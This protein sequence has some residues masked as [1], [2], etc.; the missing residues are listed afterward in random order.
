MLGRQDNHDA[1]RL[2]DLMR[3][4][5]YPEYLALGT[6]F[7]YL[8]WD[9]VVRWTVAA[10][11]RFNDLRLIGYLGSYRLWMRRCRRKAARRLGISLREASFGTGRLSRKRREGSE[12]KGIA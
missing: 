4:I 6:S 1:G 5:L 9:I 2:P 11:D 7:V 10:L 8:G 12:L 3:P